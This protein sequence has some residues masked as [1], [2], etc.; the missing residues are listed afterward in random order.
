MSSDSTELTFVRCPSCRSLVPAV[1]TR[2]RMCG[3]KLD[4]PGAVEGEHK[5]Q[6]KRVR[7]RT[8][9]ED[10]EDVSSAVE[11]IRQEL[12][13]QDDSFMENSGQEGELEAEAPLEEEPPAATQA[14]VAQASSGVD[15]EE[16]LDDPLSDYLEDL[17]DE[18]GDFEDLE[19]L[20]AEDEEEDEFEEEVEEEIDEF[21]DSEEDFLSELD[22]VEDEAI[23]AAEKSQTVE[24]MSPAKNGAIAAAMLAVS[25]EVAPV[26]SEEPHVTAPPVVTPVVEPAPIPPVEKAAEPARKESAK[27]KVVIESGLRTRGRSNLSFGKKKEDLQVHMP[28]KAETEVAAMSPRNGAPQMPEPVKVPEEIAEPAISEPAQSAQVVQQEFRQENKAEAPAEKQIQKEEKMEQEVQVSEERPCSVHP[29]KREAPRKGVLHGWLVNYTDPEGVSVEL[30]EGRFFASR[31]SLKASDLIVD[32]PSVSTPHAL[33][34]VGKEGVTI[35]DLMSEKGVF[36]R[37]AEG[38]AYSK[39]IDSFEVHHGDWVRLGDVEFLVSMIA[40]VGVK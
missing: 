1:S 9:S 38:V 39:E 22:E 3:S 20:I 29:V 13:D 8:L 23:E 11:Q 35:Q 31:S 40:H 5:E 33:I 32:D 21:G 16:D 17:D 15:A 12:Q 25:Q 14:S 7:Q 10:Q 30:R 28:T 34:V 37:A 6:G 27:P 19:E 26:V 2:C 18:D 36:H 24:I 4:T